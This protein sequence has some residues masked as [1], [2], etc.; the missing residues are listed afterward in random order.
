MHVSFLGPSSLILEIQMILSFLLIVAYVD[1]YI[2][3]VL[4]SFQGIY[5][6]ISGTHSHVSQNFIENSFKTRMWKYCSFNGHIFRFLSPRFLVIVM[7]SI[8][9]DVVENVIRLKEKRLSP[10]QFTVNICVCVCVCV[11]LDVLYMCA[12]IYISTCTDMFFTQVRPYHTCCS[13]T[14]LFCCD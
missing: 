2:G 5:I 8:H 10:F 12:S 14:C 4:N 7:F 9:T 3:P 13:V 6:S 11:L 1:A